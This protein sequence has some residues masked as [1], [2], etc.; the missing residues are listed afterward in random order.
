MAIDYVEKH[1]GK[2]ET[3]EGMCGAKIPKR[4]E[5]GREVG[6]HYVVICVASCK[7]LNLQLPWKESPGF[8]CSPR[9]GGFE[10]CIG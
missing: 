7:L 2:G 3:E 4:R 6:L 1:K 10:L 8:F 9:I 5:V